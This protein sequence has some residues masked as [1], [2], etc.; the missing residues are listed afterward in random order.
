MHR[1][2]PGPCPVGDGDLAD[3][4]ETAEQDERAGLHWKTRT[5]VDRAAGRPFIWLDD[6]ITDA[7]RTWVAAHHP[8]PALL[9]RVDP[10]SGIAQADY[11]AVEEWLRTLSS[12]PPS[13]AP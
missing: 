13:N 11:A 5:L 9:H 1:A 4:P 3:T 6:E 2:A 10:S 12:T 7:D 8:G